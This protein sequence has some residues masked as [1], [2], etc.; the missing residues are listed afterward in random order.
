MKNTGVRV[1]NVGCDD[2]Q[3]KALHKL[4]CACSSALYTE[5]NNSAGSV[6][7][8]LFSAFV[9]LVALKSGI[10]YIGYLLIVLKELGNLLCI[11][12]MSLHS[13]SKGL[14]SEVQHVAVHR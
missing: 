4:F 12:T 6:R 14:K 13:D 8:V 11:F 10:S 7:H 1:G 5:G 2:G 9:V 3:L